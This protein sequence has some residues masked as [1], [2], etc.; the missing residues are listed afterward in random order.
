MQGDRL[1][2]IGRSKVAIYDHKR[3]E[4]NRKKPYFLISAGDVLELKTRKVSE[5]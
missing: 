2:V 1:E 5:K 4:A 3:F